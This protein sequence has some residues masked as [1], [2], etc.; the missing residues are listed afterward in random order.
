M[1]LFRCL[2]CDDVRRLPAPL[3]NNCRGATCACGARYSREEVERLAVTWRPLPDGMGT[4][5]TRL[6]ARSADNTGGG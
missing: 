6:V 1:R 4:D 3:P 2:A 5:L